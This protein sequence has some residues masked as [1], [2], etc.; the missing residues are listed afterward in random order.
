M[1]S[2][3]AFHSIASHSIPWHSIPFHSSTAMNSER[4]A[5]APAYPLVRRRPLV[6]VDDDGGSCALLAWSPPR[7]AAS[8]FWRTCEKQQAWL[9]TCI[10][11]WIENVSST[12]SSS[13]RPSVVV[14]MTSSP[15]VRVSSAR[16]LP[17]GEN[18]VETM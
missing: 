17:H 16:Y 14:D 18:G 1:N 13:H 9:L 12:V 8:G 4:F 2:A 10:P 15:P 5:S 6:S 11:S 3:H 7:V